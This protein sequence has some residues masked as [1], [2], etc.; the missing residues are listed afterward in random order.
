MESVTGLHRKSLLGRINGALARKPC[1]KQQGK[2]YGAEVDAAIRK[3]AKSLDDPCAERLQPNLVWMAEHLERHGELRLTSELREQLAR[4]SVSSVRR[5]LPR[6]ERAA[7]RIA[8]RKG[9]PRQTFAQKH[10]IPMRRIDWTECRPG[11]FEVNLVHHCGV[12][13]DGQYV[14]TLQ[15]LDVA[16]GWSECVA[17][18]RTSCLLRKKPNW[19]TCAARPIRWFFARNS[20][21]DRSLYALPGLQEGQVEDVRLSLFAPLEDQ[22]AL[23][24]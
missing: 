19:K 12:S 18:Q 1:R 23:T 4:I 11:H 24:G 22:S 6:T 7:E 17:V 15:L 14:H 2:T 9:L 21:P 5:R 10:S 16:T 20:E 3:I 8:H 13:A